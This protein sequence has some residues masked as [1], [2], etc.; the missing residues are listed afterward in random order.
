MKKGAGLA[1]R[2]IAEID[3]LIREKSREYNLKA[4]IDDIIART[5]DPNR[6]LIYQDNFKELQ[7]TGGKLFLPLIFRFGNKYGVQ[8]VFHRF[9]GIFEVNNAN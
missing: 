4:R 9:K 6:K 5:Q 3:K 1:V 7:E 2:D 8:I